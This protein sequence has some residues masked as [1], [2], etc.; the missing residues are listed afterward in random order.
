MLICN[1]GVMSYEDPSKTVTE[2]GLELH[3]AVNYLG[4]FYLVH[5]LR[6]LLVASG[7]GRVVVVS[8]ILLKE[9]QVDTHQLGRPGLARHTPGRT[10]PAYSDS[11]L[12]LALFSRELQR[13]EPRLVVLT[14]SPGWCRTSLGRSA[15]IS[16]LAWPALA[17]LLLLVGKSVRQGADTI[18]FCAAQPG[19]QRLR[20]KF[21]RDR[22]VEISIETFLDQL[23]LKTIT[24]WQETVNIMQTLVRDG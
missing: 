24:L 2:D 13:R 23:V 6:S 4:H 21:I 22:E 18:V 8:S 11:K 16:C 12:L 5:L 14:V 9:G 17:L 20:G 3:F 1:A 10:P 7:E 15:Q 19:L